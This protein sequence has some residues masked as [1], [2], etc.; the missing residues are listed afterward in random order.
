ML[1]AATIR[2]RE[3]AE[4]ALQQQ[5]N[6]LAHVTRVATVGELSGAIAHADALFQVGGAPW[7]PEIF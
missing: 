3:R 4:E 2:E 5:R 6:Q 7:C 1:L